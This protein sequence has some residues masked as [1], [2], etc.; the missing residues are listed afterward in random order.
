MDFISSM[1]DDILHHILSFTPIKLAIITSALSRRWRHVW[2]E[3]PCLD[4]DRYDGAREINQTLN[5]YRAQKIMSFD[6]SLPECFPEPQ[7]DSWIEF[8]MSR[9]WRRCL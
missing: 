1:P 2:C 5:S 7:I 3:T 9:M 4:F 6:L 8:A